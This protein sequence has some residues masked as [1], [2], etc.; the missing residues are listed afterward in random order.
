MWPLKNDD[1][2]SKG[3]APNPIHERYPK[4]SR[5]AGASKMTVYLPGLSAR[6]FFP[7]TA[8]LAARSA[9]AVG[10][11]S[12]KRLE[13]PSA[14]PLESEPIAFTLI[15]LSV[16]W[17]KRRTPLEFPITNASDWVDT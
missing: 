7:A 15:A 8:F 12:E 10:S 1:P 2:S 6:G 14:Y 9:S 17:W 5:N 11:R 16:P 3:C 4:N 13:K